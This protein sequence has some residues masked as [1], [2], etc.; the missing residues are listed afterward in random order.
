MPE[1]SRF[2]GIVIRIHN[3]EHG[4][5]HFHASYGDANAVFAID[6]LACIEGQLPRRAHAMVIEWGGLHQAEILQNWQCAQRH[7][8]LAAIEP[9][10]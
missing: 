7:Q 9:L 3:R 10:Q 4:V 8:P 5:P 2:F 6:T 1:I